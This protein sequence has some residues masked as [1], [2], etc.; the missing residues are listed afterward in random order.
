MAWTSSS[1]TRPSL[2]PPSRMRRA[3]AYTCQA[4]ESPPEIAATSLLGHRR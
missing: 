4:G 2:S 3:A 1:A